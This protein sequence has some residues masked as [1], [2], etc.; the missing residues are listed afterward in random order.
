MSAFLISDFPVNYVHRFLTLSK[1][2]VAW[3][4]K[5]ETDLYW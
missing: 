4:M 5:N 1:P 2:E 3:D